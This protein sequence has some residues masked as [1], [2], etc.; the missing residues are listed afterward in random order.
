L[1]ASSAIFHLGVDEDRVGQAGH[2]AD[3]LE[4]LLQLAALSRCAIFLRERVVAAVGGHR[5]ITQPSGAL[6][7]AKLVS[8]PPA[9]ARSRK[10]RSRCFLRDD[11]LGLALVP[12]NRIV[13]PSAARLLTKSSI[14]KEQRLASED[15]D[16]VPF[17]EDEFLH[18]E[19]H[20]LMA[21]VHAGLRIFHRDHS[22]NPL[23]IAD[24]KFR[25]LPPEL[26]AGKRAAPAVCHLA[27]LARIAGVNVTD[28]PA[29]RYLT[30]RGR[31][32]AASR[33]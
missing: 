26:L 19:F 12:T 3:A 31:Y 2:A 9:T 8:S 11:V 13:R 18:L 25:L 28:L 6:I 20:G 22:S 23:N 10:C 14:A 16:A 1:R 7:V 29:Q 33:G 17:A 30:A 4:V 32:Q 24:C 21:E 27:F 15:V 5:F